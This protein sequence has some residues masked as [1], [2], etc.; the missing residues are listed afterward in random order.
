MESQRQVVALEARLRGC[1]NVLTLGV[2]ANYSDYRPVEKVIVSASVIDLGFIR[3]RNSVY[4][5]EQEMDYSFE[6][7]EFTLDEDWD[8]GEELLDSLRGRCGGGARSR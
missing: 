4:N 8:P 1:K 7:L 5:F 6:G 3:W 2:R